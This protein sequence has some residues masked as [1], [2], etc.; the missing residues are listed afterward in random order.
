M[1]THAMII[2]F[3]KSTYVTYVTNA[4]VKEQVIKKNNLKCMTNTYYISLAMLKFKV[5]NYESIDQKF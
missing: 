2:W 3:K 5:K 4:S 1:D